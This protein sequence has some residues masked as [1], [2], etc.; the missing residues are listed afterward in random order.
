[1]EAGRHH[2]CVE[3][4]SENADTQGRAFT[5]EP[6]IDEGQGDVL[7]HAVSV[8]TGGDGAHQ[9]VTR[10][11]R[12]PAMGRL[13]ETIVWRPQQTGE[14]ELTM[15]V[16]EQPTEIISEN[17]ALTVPINIRREALRVL[18]VESYPRWE[19]RYTRNALD[20]MP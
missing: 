19:Y 7:P 15:R 8:P 5:C 20:W 17:N 2:T 4:L 16:P 10:V 11:D 6:G 12:I 3:S 1:M 14:F 9:L 18:F 13:Q